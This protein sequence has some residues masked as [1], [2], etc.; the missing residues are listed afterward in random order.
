MMGD[1]AAPLLHHASSS[2]CQVY[3]IRPREYQLGHIYGD[4]DKT[5]GTLLLWKL[6]S[7]VKI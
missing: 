6:A 5:P 2:R 1:K 3:K 4:G 7:G